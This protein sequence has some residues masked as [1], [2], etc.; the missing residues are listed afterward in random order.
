MDDKF[1]NLLDILEKEIDVYREFL[2]LLQMERQYMVDLS[3]DR[4]HDCS[5]Q[6]E[7]IILDLKV[8][9]ESRMDITASIQN[10]SNSEFLTLS[11]IIDMAPARYK[12]GLESCRSNLVSLINSIKEINQINGILAKR[13]VNYTRNSL[14][15]L[16]RIVNELPV[17]LPSGHME[18][19]NKTGKLVCKRG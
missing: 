17:Y 7:T 15:F 8:L 14:S 3:L 18:Q 13:A 19:D 16:N 11:M 5:N 4:L 12:K 1:E 2:N 10:S 9:E 6:K